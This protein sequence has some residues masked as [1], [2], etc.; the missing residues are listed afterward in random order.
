[1]TNSAFTSFTTLQR[2]LETTGDT[3][4]YMS[5]IPAM[6]ARCA[7]Q[8]TLMAHMLALLVYL[9][10]LKRFDAIIE[11]TEQTKD[12]NLEA[13]ALEIAFNQAPIPPLPEPAKL[14][15]V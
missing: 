13:Y 9:E 4:L 7:E 1:M 10:P 12:G 6:V 11:I 3:G 14:K 15:V 5:A 8:P 2:Q